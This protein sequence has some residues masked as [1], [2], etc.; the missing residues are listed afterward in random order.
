MT[1]IKN[2]EF[3]ID[4]IDPLGQGVFKKG[5]DIFFIPK[6]LPNESATAQVLKRK[7]GVHFAKLSTLD[8]HSPNRI[9][10]KCEHFDSCQGCHFLHTDY[11]SEIQFKEKSFK[12]M[13]S[14]LNIEDI[15]INTTANNRL[16]Y[17]NRVQL[18]YNLNAK[19]LGF[20][21]G[22][23][24]SIVQIPKCLICNEKVSS[25]LKELYKDIK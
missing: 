21:D 9:K 7:K 16:H 14:Y 8:N 11:G 19:K 13:L 3:I 24:N 22:K 17:R 6:T 20:I 25:K 23:S 4:H 10:P 18:H 1:I 15:K 12:K 2:I 5:D